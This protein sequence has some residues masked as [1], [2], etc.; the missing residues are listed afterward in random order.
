VAAL[1]FSKRA[2]S[3]LSEIGLYTLQTWGENQAIRYIDDLETCCRK[4][5]GNP[6]LG[7]TCNSIRPGLR[8]LQCGKHVIFYRQEPGG[9]FVSRILRERMLP[10]R[11]MIDERE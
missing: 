9:I 3:D 11:H 5:A 4:L 8:R 7:R 10:E 6:L 1:R 2:E